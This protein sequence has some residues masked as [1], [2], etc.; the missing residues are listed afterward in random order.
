MTSS[1]EMVATSLE[2]TMLLNPFHC[3]YSV[4][5]IAS[6]SNHSAKFAKFVIDKDPQ[7]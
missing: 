2:L 1:A 6:G 7:K 3:S 4:C 5:I